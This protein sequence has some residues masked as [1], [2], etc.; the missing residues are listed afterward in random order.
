LIADL[1]HFDE[2]GGWYTQGFTPLR[3]FGSLLASAGIQRPRASER[4]SGRA[5]PA[6][7]KV[8][9]A[10]AAG[11]LSYSKAPSDHPRHHE[12]CTA[13]QPSAA[14][15]RLS[16]AAPTTVIA[17]PRGALGD[18]AAD[19]LRHGVHQ[20]EAAPEEAALLMQVIE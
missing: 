11:T 18:R 17:A 1:R 6:L 2:A 5:L 15:T 7:P 13:S 3:A 20:G 16:S 10:L 19:D 14:S 8:D 9:A 12:V 4:A